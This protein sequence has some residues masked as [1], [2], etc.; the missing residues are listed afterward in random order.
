MQGM[1]LGYPG[2]DFTSPKI[3]EKIYLIKLSHIKEKEDCHEKREK[4]LA[5]SIMIIEN[6]FFS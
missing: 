6:P 4:A 3:C 2:T 5:V 1:L